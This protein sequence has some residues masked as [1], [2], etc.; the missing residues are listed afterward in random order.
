[1]RLRYPDRV[2]RGSMPNN[3]FLP[4]LPME[5]ILE[6][7]NRNQT[8]L[9]ALGQL[10]LGNRLCEWLDRPKQTEP[11]LTDMKLF[12]TLFGLGLPISQYWTTGPGPKYQTRIICTSIIHL[13][14]DIAILVI[15]IPWI[16]G[17][18]MARLY[19][20]L[21]RGILSLGFL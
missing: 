7:A 6:R 5:S 21:I 18:D 16:A 8:H 11:E 3:T 4:L 20:N 9:V 13:M 17:Q 10:P 2:D 19:K 12:A 15:P 14:I 1:M